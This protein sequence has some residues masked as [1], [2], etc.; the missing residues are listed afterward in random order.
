MPEGQI[1]TSRA[2]PG[3][4]PSNL[5][6]GT[7]A[8]AP[9]ATNH[10]PLRHPG[11]NPQNPA[12]RSGNGWVKS[13]IRFGTSSWPFQNPIKSCCGEKVRASTSQHPQQVPDLIIH[14]AGIRHRLRHFLT[15]QIPIALAQ[16]EGRQLH[17]A[18]RHP[19]P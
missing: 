3:D 15:D 8:A 4:H 11:P 2:F 14:L 18:F 6:A 7:H 1:Q 16:P 12:W 13:W 5:P 9:F 19:Q 10:D 17:G